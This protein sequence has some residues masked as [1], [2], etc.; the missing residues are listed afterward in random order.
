MKW[1][2]IIIMVLLLPIVMADRGEIETYKPGE[3]L[4]LGIHL[5]NKT[6]DVS[7]ALCQVQ[8][9]NESYGDI[10]NATLNELGGGWYNFTFN[11]SKVGKY[12]CRQNCTMGS[13]FASETCDFIIGVEDNMAFSMIIIIPLFIAI[14]LLIVSW[15]LE[16]EKYWALKLGLIMLGFVFIFQAYQMSSLVISEFFV[17]DNITN[18][19]ADSTWIYGMSFVIIISVFLITF[20]YDI[21][22]IF[23][24]KKH[25]TGDYEN[26]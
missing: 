14:F 4:D 11:T 8:I 26:E 25:K 21:F 22:M 18:A 1:N 17:S 10:L 9:L 20:I 7:G 12:F 15:M 5:S 2:L 16:A 19:I 3:L 24:S 13:L 23:D 6:G